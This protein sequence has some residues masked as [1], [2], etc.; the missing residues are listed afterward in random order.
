MPIHH[1]SAARI[2]L[3]LQSQFINFETNELQ[4]C[5]SFDEV[6]DALT[7]TERRVGVVTADDNGYEYQFIRERRRGCMPAAAS[8]QSRHCERGC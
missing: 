4:Q 8:C 1:S 7:A 6:D 5:Q 2:E 3:W